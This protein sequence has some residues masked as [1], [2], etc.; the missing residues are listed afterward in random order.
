MLHSVE[1]VIILKSVSIFADVAEAYLSELGEIVAEHEFN[2]GERIISKGEP[3]TSM[4]VIVNGKVRIHTDEKTIATLGPREVFGELATLDPEPRSAH[5]SA[6]GHVHLLSLEQEPLY[7]LMS[8]HVE[9]VRSI[10][11]VLCNR[12]RGNLK[13]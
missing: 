6:E 2:D 11:R 7:E 10:N 3:G 13:K 4:Y 9:I 5:V 1:K 12:I 8:E